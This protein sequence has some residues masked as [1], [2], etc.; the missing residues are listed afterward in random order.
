MHDIDYI[1]VCLVDW[2]CVPRFH[3]FSDYATLL[4]TVEIHRD[5][6][7]V[8]GGGDED[9]THLFAERD[10]FASQ[11]LGVV[12]TMA[13]Q[14]KELQARSGEGD[15]QDISHVRIGTES[16]KKMKVKRTLLEQQLN[17]LGKVRTSN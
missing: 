16:R 15:V 13:T 6:S 4:R 11:L 9:L 2:K 7:E 5:I 3:Q 1:F 17:D 8:S 10:A 12:K 14:M